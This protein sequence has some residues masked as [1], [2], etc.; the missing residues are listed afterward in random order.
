MYLSIELLSF[1]SYITW[2]YLLP[3]RC[4]VYSLSLQYLMDKSSYFNVIGWK[5]FSYSLSILWIV[6]IYYPKV[7]K[8]YFIFSPKSFVLLPFTLGFKCA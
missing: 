8:N 3:I 1:V 5:F 4:L 7:L 2:N 6:K